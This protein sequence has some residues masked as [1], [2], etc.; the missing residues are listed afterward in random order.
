ML[1]TVCTVH[2][3]EGGDALWCGEQVLI[4]GYGAVA[5]FNVGDENLCDGRC[6]MFH[7]DFYGI[8]GAQAEQ[9]TRRYIQN[10]WVYIKYSLDRRFYLN[11]HPTW[12]VSLVTYI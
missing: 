6:G 8:S 1:A 12:L 9:P 10:I 3:S 5:G 4:I 2:G 7:V 11:F